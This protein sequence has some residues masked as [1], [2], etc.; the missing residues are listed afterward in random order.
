MIFLFL[1]P[2]YL[3]A[4]IYMLVR[5]FHWLK[6]CHHRL[7]W[8]R[9]KIPFT[10]VYIAMAF[11]PILA[12]FLPKS[13]F[14]VIVRRLS[15][16][17]IGVLMYSA[18][19]VGV[20]EILRI[21][22]KHTK[23]KNT[24]LFSRG[25]TVTVGSIVTACAVLLCVYG[26][27][28][29]RNIRVTEYS[30]S[31][32]K[33]CE[34]MDKLNIVLVADLHLGYSIGVHQMEKMVDRINEQDADLVVIAGDIFDN[35][36]DSLDDPEG[37]KEQFH[38]IKSK[39]GVYAT[40]GNHDIEEKILMGFTFSWGESPALSQQMQ[41]F[42]EDCGMKVLYDESVLV[43][44][45]F[46]LVGRRDR[47]KPGT[48]DGSRAAISE[49]TKD[50]DKT[51]PVFVIAHEPDELQETADAGADLDL[52]GH[53]HDGQLFPL[54]VIVRTIWEN[55]CGVLKKDDMTSIVTS[56]VG[57]YGPFMRVGTRAE[58]CSITVEF[59]G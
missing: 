56:G 16:Y 57:V 12:F 30:V 51:K 45:K 49:L 13:S 40:M 41:D 8:K 59:D 15:T 55:P 22:A 37:I 43:D 23:L 36:Y 24:R 58:I 25:G 50:L 44:N 32:N 11:S 9:V 52:S 39:Y 21:I 29:A 26:G 53:T 28:N 54:T 7:A 42:V 14:A 35:S 20:F 5:F 4:V 6:H 38:R 2:L 46:Y 18:I 3:A 10:V 48:E 27:I 1:L 17:W 31:V 33:K 19:A 34:G 47:D